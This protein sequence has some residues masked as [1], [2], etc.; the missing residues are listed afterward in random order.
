MVV[1]LKKVTKVP[2]DFEVNTNEVFF[3]GNLEYYQGKLIL[4]RAKLKGLI[5]KS[6]DFCG[7]EF[8]LSLDENIEFFISDGIY[9]SRDN[10]DLDVVES[11][12]GSVD[13]HDLLN[14]ELELIK[15]DYHACKNC[16]ESRG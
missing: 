4:L 16:Q 12:T 9:E 5:E 7:D 13:M 11:F 14:S 10:I 2:L 3:K 1:T 8:V 6:C 15:S